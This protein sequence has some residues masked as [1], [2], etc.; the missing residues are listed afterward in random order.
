MSCRPIKRREMRRMTRAYSCRVAILCEAG[1]DRRRIVRSRVLHRRRGDCAQD[2]WQAYQLDRVSSI[3][4]LDR[5]LATTAVIGT[6]CMPRPPR[7][8]PSER[9]GRSRPAAHRPC[10]PPCRVRGRAPQAGRALGRSR[11]RSAPY[12]LQHRTWQRRDCWRPR[13]GSRGCAATSR[14]RNRSGR[15]WRSPAA[16]ARAPARR[17]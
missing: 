15:A 17:H 12:R 16:P 4:S 11:S 14:R 8:W 3:D 10:R 13:S 1:T 9:C 6:S 2:D 7:P 5:V